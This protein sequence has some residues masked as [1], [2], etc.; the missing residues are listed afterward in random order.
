YLPDAKVSEPWKRDVI[1]AVTVRGHKLQIFDYQ[2]APQAQL[3]DADV[4]IDHGG[5]RGTHAMADAATPVK[6]WEIL[7][8]GIRTFD[9]PYWKS[10]RMRVANCPGVCSGVALAECALMYI[11]MLSRGWNQTQA[12]LRA[13]IAYTPPGEEVAGRSIG[14]IGLGGS[15]RELAVRAR[16]V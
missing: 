5:A 15:G 1:K 2:A 14:I 4:V 3:A 10:K 7:C 6:L 11:L 12:N 13:G 8:T 9:L 16:A